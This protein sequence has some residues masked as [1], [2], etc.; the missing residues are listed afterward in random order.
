MRELALLLPG[1]RIG[2]SCE[3]RIYEGEESLVKLVPTIGSTFLQKD[4]LVIGEAT[5]GVTSARVAFAW[6]TRSSSIVKAYCNLDFT[7]EGSHIKGFQQGLAKALGRRDDEVVFNALAPGLRAAISVMVV[8]PEFGAPTRER[9]VSDVARRVVCSATAIAL[10]EAL[11]RPIA[12]SRLTQE[13]TLGAF[14]QARLQRKSGT[15]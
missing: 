10:S 6:N 1:L 9:L 11:A 13:E 2:F 3:P 12:P 5:E 7:P 8:D 15:P 4:T 14:L